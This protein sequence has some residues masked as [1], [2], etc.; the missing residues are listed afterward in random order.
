MSDQNASFSP[1]SKLMT[2]LKRYKSKY[3]LNM[4][5]KGLLVTA[6]LLLTTYIIINAAEYFGKF[7]TTIRAGL[8]YTFLAAAVVT[9]IAWVL[10]PISKLL[11]INK[12]ISD[13]EAAVQIGKYFPNVDDKL[14]NTIQLHN[15]ADKDNALLMA[16]IEQRTSQLGIVKFTDAVR[17]SENR[18]YLRYVVPPL[19]VLLLILIITPTFFSESSARIINYDNEY[20][21]PAPFTFHLANKNLKAFKNEDFVVE[22]DLKGRTMPPDVYL[23]SGGRRYK[24]EK[25]RYDKF[26]YT[27]K[28]IQKATEF[29]FE[30]AGFSSQNHSVSLIERPTLLSFSANLN[31]PAYLNKASENW[32]NIGN[33]V[34]PEGTQIQWN[35]KTNNSKE[36]ALF[37]NEGKD[38][39]KAEKVNPKTFKYNR[40][41]R[42]SETYQVKLKNEFSGNKEDINYYINVIPDRYPKI[43]IKEYKDTTMYDYLSIGGSVSDDYGLSQLKMFYRITRDGKP[44]KL[45]AV[46]LQLNSGQSIQNYYYQMDLAPMNLQ[47]GDNL[48]YFAQVWDNDGVNGAKSAKTTALTFKIPGEE[49]LKKEIDKAAEKT[50]NQIDKTLNQARKLKE[51]MENVKNRFRNKRYMDYQDKK[52]VKELLEKRQELI[53]EIKKI[54]EQNETTNQK[55]KRFSETSPEV[56]QKMQQLKKLMDELL[57]E[58]TKKLYE[59]LQKLLEQTRRNDRIQNMLDKIQKKEENLDKELER[60]LEM[61]KQLKFEQKLD[62]TSKDLQKLAKKQDKLAEK[63]DK[64]LKDKSDKNNTKDNNK[65]DKKNGKNKDQKSDKNDKKNS[66]DKSDKKESNESLQKKQKELTKKFDEIKKQLE[67]LKKMDKKLE[68]P[69]DMK[70]FKQEKED[71]SKEQQNSQKQLQQKQ[72][73]KA[74][75]SQKKAAKKMKKMAQQMQ[76]MQQN[77]QKQQMQENLD[78]LRAIL[79]NLVTLSFDQEKL[80]K[81]FR[82]VSLS[83]PRFV[84]LGQKQLKLR[85]DAKIIE[86]SLNALAKRVFQ[87]KSFVTREVGKMKNYMDESTDMI[88]RRRLSI[89]TGKQQF[90]MTSMNNL[91]LLLNDVMKQMQNSMASAMSKPQKGKKGKPKPNLGQLQKSLNQKI[92]QLKKSGKQGRKLSEE[93]AKLAAEQEQIRQALKEMQKRMGK[94][95]KNGKDLRELQ[96]KMEE[97]E[98]NLVFKNLEQITKLRQKDILTR[99]LESEKSLREQ[100][101]DKERKS[102]SAK[103]QKIRRVPPALNQYFKNKAKQI[104]LLKTIPPALSP[105]YKKEV[106]EYFEKIDN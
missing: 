11:N 95:G 86:D 23:V 28:K 60:A 22:L 72:N 39:V 13:E 50:E 41:A 32:D 77:M 36:L 84:K 51:S 3:Y 82:S 35:F 98:K 56:K 70:D 94:D 15:A 6:A 103:D 88:K 85:D 99:L 44:G 69:N 96:K 71:I 34:V 54:Q 7:N 105:Y 16:S 33:L 49:E 80:M 52:Q 2:E 14:L 46:D 25:S 73:K 104:E 29:K 93:L 17:F 65:S 101:Q 42:R 19:L 83:D 57:D 91:A 40:S 4:L 30:S 61:F 87:I 55:Q 38:V 106:D 102:K 31:Y 59:E 62:Q 8:F 75:K 26:S 74:G 63:T 24:M 81:D 1:S 21:E 53:K 64:N 67:D 66:S 78:D 5:F 100:G 43:N 68:F 97:V 58:E 76:Q 47:P 12:Q 89:A 9:L 90:A 18:R 45:Q 92:Q 20:V 79:E 27:F 48:E 37:F 10:W